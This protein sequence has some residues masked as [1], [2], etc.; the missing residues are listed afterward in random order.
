[1]NYFFKT[2]V[3]DHAQIKEKLL[4]QI[5]LIPKNSFINENQNIIHTDWNIP[6]EKHPEY[7]D[8][9]F[10]TVRG[11]IETMTKAL[12]CLRFEIGAYWFQ[13][14]CTSGFHTWHTHGGCHFTNIYF[15]ECP[16]GFETKFK[17]MNRNIEEGDIISFPAFVPHCSPEIK[18][19]KERKTIISFNTNFYIL[20]D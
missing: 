2:K 1:M 12:D 8:L 20:G 13:Q 15:V 9:F 7:Y 4:E 3:E 19:A 18:D 6:K 5:N 14:Y 11:H 16:K 17:D 10:N